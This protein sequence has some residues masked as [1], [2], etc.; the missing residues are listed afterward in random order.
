MYYKGKDD[1]IGRLITLME[2]Q[3][4]LRYHG[5]E[6]LN[7]RNFEALRDEVNEEIEMLKKKDHSHV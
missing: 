3:K 5:F 6:N 7:L 2:L 1:Y 4:Q